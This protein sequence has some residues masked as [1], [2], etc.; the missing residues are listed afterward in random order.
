MEC[1]KDRIHRIVDEIRILERDLEQA[2]NAHAPHPL[3][4]IRGA[5]IHFEVEVR[6]SHARLRT[7]L[8]DWFRLSQ[9]RNIA[10]APLVYGMILPFACLDAWLFAYQA[11]CFRLYRIPAV[12]RSDYI[13]I[14]RRH[15]AYLNIVERF[16]CIYCGY[17]NGLLAFS[18]EIAARTEQYWCPIKHAR[19]VLGAHNRYRSFL[20]FGD[21]EH[22]PDGLEGYRESLRQESCEAADGA[23]SER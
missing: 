6:D 4:E 2:I 23:Q 14:D 17:T 16:N 7:G 20:E 1:T 8:A 11:V 5:D 13:S 19:K 15:L 18:A 21:A 12:R 10:S 22:Y 9:W 3:Y